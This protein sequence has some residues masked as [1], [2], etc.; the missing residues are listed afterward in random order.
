MPDFKSKISEKVLEKMVME[1][2]EIFDAW[3]EVKSEIQEKN[4]RA[5]SDYDKAFDAMMNVMLREQKGFTIHEIFLGIDKF[6]MRINKLRKEKAA[7]AQ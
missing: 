4:P 3:Q 5:T 7:K 1:S 2:K 6:L